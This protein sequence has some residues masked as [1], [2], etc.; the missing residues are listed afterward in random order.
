MNTILVLRLPLLVS[1]PVSLRFIVAAVVLLAAITLS[2]YGAL[3]IGTTPTRLQ[4]AL[5]AL[6]QAP[7]SLEGPARTIGQFRLP[8]ILVAL[9]AGAM[10]AAS[11]YL[12]QVVSRNGLAD[13]GILGLADGAALAVIGATFFWTL[14]PGSTLSLIALAGAL[15]TA[16]LVLGL[17][18]RVLSSGGII[19]VGLSIN[20]VL[21]GAI[22][23][24]LVA[25]STLDFARLMTW[26][27]GTLSTVDRADFHLLAVWCAMLLPLSLLT[28]RMLMPMLLGAEAAQALGVRAKLVSAW[29]VLLAAAFAAPVVAS[30]G[31]VAFVGLMSAYVARAIVGERPTEVLLTSMGCGG[32]ILLWADTVG[33]SLF[34]PI[35]VSAGIMVAVVGVPSFI[36]AAAISSRFSSFHRS[37]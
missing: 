30:C 8:R 11:G 26:S 17:G 9:L 34:S 23:M 24:M 14:V 5:A 32:L 13:P 37:S 7:E 4:D 15:G 2:A 25:G 21:G 20:I 10:M 16:M 19:L 29:Y 35:M 31:P 1:M 33:R 22:E 27:R 12:L 36:L 6:L 3:N 18:R 28:S